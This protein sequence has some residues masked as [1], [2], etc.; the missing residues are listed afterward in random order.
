MT[1]TTAHP[2]IPLD[3]F[4]AGPDRGPDDPVGAGGLALHERHWHA[5]GASAVR[6]AFAADAIDELVLDLVPVLLGRGVRLF[7]GVDDPGLQ[8]VE[9]VHSPHATHV[10][11][12]VR[13]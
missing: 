9:V 8:P 12:R 13:H 11:H 10:R 1:H 6:Q 2:S 7:D 4:V 3:G 5:G